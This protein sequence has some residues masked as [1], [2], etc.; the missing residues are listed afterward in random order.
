MIFRQES[1]EE[2]VANIKRMG[3]LE[4]CP[5]CA[6]TNLLADQR[7][8]VADVGGTQN[9]QDSAT[10]ITYH[11]RV[12]CDGCGYVLLFDAER[13]RSGDHPLFERV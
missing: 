3:G 7:P 1:I 10:N 2:I 6:G 5:I 12:V 8:M 11:L 13:H 9:L 4:A